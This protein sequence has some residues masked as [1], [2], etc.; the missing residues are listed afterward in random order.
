MA[1]RK[2]KQTDISSFFTTSKKSK[3]SE[4]I[5][6]K[7]NSLLKAWPMTLPDQNATLGQL[8]SSALETNPD[9]GN[10]TTSMSIEDSE[11]VSSSK[12]DF[13]SPIHIDKGYNLLHINTLGVTAQ[14][15]TPTCSSIAAECD[16]GKLLDSGID[17]Q[18]LSREE[19]Y[20]ILTT[21]PSLDP[22]SYPRTRPYVSGSFCQD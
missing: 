11:L 1:Q 7:I 16:I 15:T 3:N 13:V 5:I 4:N 2:R 21:N 22:S 19:K 9:T 18:K 12:S 10:A 20:R 6:Y 14:N 17:L 8:E